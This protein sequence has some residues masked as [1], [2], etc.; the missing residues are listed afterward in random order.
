MKEFDDQLDHLLDRLRSGMATEREVRELEDSLRSDAGMRRRYMERV[1]MEEEL[2][3]SFRTPADL[4]LP[5]EPAQH[6][7]RR[8]SPRWIAAI[9]AGITAFLVAVSLLRE[10]PPPTVAVLESRSG[11]SW[12]RPPLMDGDLRIQPGEMRLETGSARLRFD[13]GAIVTLEGPAGLVVESAMRA[14]LLFGKVLVEAPE[15]AHRFAISLPHGEAV[16]LGTR[17]SVEVNE[18]QAT[19]EVLDGRI[20]MRHDASQQVEYLEEGQVMAMRSQ[21]M[22]SLDYLPSANFAPDD[23]GRVILRASGETTV[24][25]APNRERYVDERFLLVKMEPDSYAM[26][27]AM[28]RIDL[29]RIKG[30]KL[31]S[32]RLNLN[33][34]PSGLGFAAYLPDEVSFA[35]YGITDERRE[36]WPREGIGWQDAPGFVAGG[37]N[38]VNPAQAA[39]LGTFRIPG[40]QQRGLCVIESGALLD[41]LRQDT[42][43]TAAFLIVRETYG[44]RE[45]SLVHAFATSLHPEANGPNLEVVLAD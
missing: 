45:H 5:F 10:N 8:I 2:S 1:W 12:S 39:L 40:G 44:T 31:E 4:P 35:V 18:T 3:A 7:S 6:G 14:K 30:R 26:R 34:V 33:L 32:A 43:G 23:V 27:R 25:T 9:A 15:S 36:Q 17:F 37:E 21:G 11:D 42:T 38:Q 29:S 20:L 13:S 22:Q 28:F 41:F 19:C 24:V 16:D